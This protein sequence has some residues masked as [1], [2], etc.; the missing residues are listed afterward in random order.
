MASHFAA[1]DSQYERLSRSNYKPQT[2]HRGH[3]GNNNGRRHHSHVGLVIGLVIVAIVAVC[4]A[5]AFQLYR[6]AMT[7]KGHA[8]DMVTEL[9]T[10]KE[11]VKSG[12]SFFG[13][14]TIPF[15]LY[16]LPSTLLQSTIPYFET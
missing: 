15:S 5:C 2:A 6:S 10:L 7:A 12:S 3:R 13:F 11:A 4:G 1:H 8:E 9:S 16:I 14:S